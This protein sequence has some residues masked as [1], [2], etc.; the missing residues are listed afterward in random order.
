MLNVSF[1]IMKSIFKVCVMYA[2]MVAISGGVSAATLSGAGTRDSLIEQE[3]LGFLTLGI[4]Y[5]NQQRDINTSS[6]GQ[7]RL[8]S[9]TIDGYIGVDPCQWLTIF[10]TLGGTAAKVTEVMPAYNDVKFQWSAGFDVNW[11]RYHIA[12]PE[13][14]DGQLSLKTHA[15]FDMH[16]SGAGD[17][18][19]DWDEYFA[20][21]LVNYETL[22]IRGQDI[23]QCPHSL[24]LYVGPALSWLS[25]NYY[26]SAGR[27]TDFHEAH[28][29][30][31]VGGAEVFVFYDLSVGASIQYYDAVT[32]DVGTRYHF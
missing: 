25:G 10:A 26:Q 20:A 8:K 24:V 21:L 28:V 17:T 19:V 6:Q 18:R 30:G 23:S 11:W 16:N 2:F 22:A 14:L 13:F 1:E 12:E 32:V 9:N 15:E 3:D 27:K 5:Q 29:F 7:M 4:D 31:V